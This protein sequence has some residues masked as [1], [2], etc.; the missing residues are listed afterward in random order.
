[1]KRIMSI[2]LACVVLSLILCGCTVKDEPVTLSSF[3]GKWEMKSSTD[4]TAL[5]IEDGK[6]IMYYT[7]LDL[8]YSNTISTRYI[9]QED[10]GHFYFYQ[11]GDCGE[12]IL[13]KDKKSVSW[14]HE[15]LGGTFNAVDS[16]D[17]E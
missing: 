14:L 15:T 2:A 9:I 11:N 8:K 10:N 4:K 7:A 3:N 6:V 13:S 12:I 5:V 17:I 1:M 16:L